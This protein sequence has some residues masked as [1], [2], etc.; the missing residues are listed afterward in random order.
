QVPTCPWGGRGL[1]WCT[2]CPPERYNFAHIPIVD[3]R[4]PLWDSGEQM[5]VVHGLRVEDR[6][7]L[8]TTVIDARPDVREPSGE[9]SLWPLIATLAVTV[10]FVC[11][12]FSPWAVLFGAVP[13]TIALIGWFWPKSP[14]PD[15]EPTIS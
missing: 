7:L 4:T 14:T 13:V 11:S 1:E 12:I 8:L 9:P 5:A 15:P 6:E 2:S 10:M 3:S